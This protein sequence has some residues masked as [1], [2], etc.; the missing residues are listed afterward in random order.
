MSDNQKRLLTDAQLIALAE[1]GG[2]RATPSEMVGVD[3]V[4]CRWMF[5]T[6]KAD[7]RRVMKRMA[8]AARGGAEQLLLFLNEPQSAGRSR[9]M[10]RVH[11]QSLE[12][13]EEDLRRYLA[14]LILVS[15]EV[16]AKAAPHRRKD[17]IE[18]DLTALIREFAYLKGDLSLAHNADDMAAHNKKPLFRFAR[19]FCHMME[20][21]IHS[22]PK[23]WLIAAP[24]GERQHLP[25]S[26][27]ELIDFLYEAAFPAKGDNP[28]KFSKLLR[29]AKSR[30]EDEE[31]V[32][33]L[34]GHVEEDGEV[35][36]LEFDPG[37]DT[38]PDEIDE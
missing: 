8:K 3:M 27:A 7:T 31:M 13:S 19:L 24:A 30:L 18:Q 38:P 4:A 33:H 15:E 11:E 34:Y 23:D 14:A 26:G 5:A 22:L 9:F 12:P 36:P 25:F 17:W 2:L 37:L 35:I 6:P 32:S 1:A 16:E 28:S 29:D 20:S 21:A 10:G